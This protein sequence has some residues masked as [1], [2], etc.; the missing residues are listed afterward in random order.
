ME[1]YDFCSIWGLRGRDR[2]VVGFILP[3][4]S[5]PIFTCEFDS[6]SDK[7]YSIQYYVIKFVS[8]LL[9]FGGLLRSTPVSSTNK[10]DRNYLTEMLLKVGSS[11]ITNPKP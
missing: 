9:Q 5:V 6:H 2:K 4:Q 1:I 8:D 7:V 10:T 3:V 11:T